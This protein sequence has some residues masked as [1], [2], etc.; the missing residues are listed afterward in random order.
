MTNQEAIENLE[1]L[2]SGDCCDN[3]MD[4]IEEIDMAIEAL[5]KQLL[6]SAID[7]EKQMANVATL[8]NGDVNKKI[9]ELRETEGGIK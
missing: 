9:K 3:Q 4:F 5:K 8:L 6:R 2:I 1:Y 7:Y